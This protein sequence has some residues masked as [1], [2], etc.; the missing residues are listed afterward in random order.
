MI[1][2]K[3]GDTAPE[4]NLID[5]RGFPVRLKDFLGKKTVVLYFYPKDFTS[6]CTTEACNFRDDYKAI[7]EKEAVV[8]GVS[9]D[10]SESHAKF[11]DKYNLPFVLLS[12]NRKEVAK[13]YGV[14]GV[15]GLLT[16]RVTFII[17][18]YGKIAAIFSKVDVKKH[19]REIL[20]TLDSMR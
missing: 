3:I 20:K 10:S 12:D 16:K 7:E 4:F 2:L 9:V 5:E 19:S 8:V 14:L 15:S 1:E 6:G 13:E 18:K 17:D 11:S